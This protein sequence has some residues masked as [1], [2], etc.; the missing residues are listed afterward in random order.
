MY[1]STKNLRRSSCRT[2]NSAFT[3]LKV[4]LSFTISSLRLFTFKSIPLF[5]K[6]EEGAGEG[7]NLFSREKKFSPSPVNFFTLIELLVVIA[8]IAILAAMLLPTLQNSMARSKRA[9]CSSNLKQLGI[10][11]NMYNNDYE[12]FLVFASGGNGSGENTKQYNSESWY[13][14]LDDYCEPSVFNCPAGPE[15]TRDY[16][17]GVKFR[18]D[19]YFKGTYAVQRLTGRGGLKNDVFKKITDVKNPSKVP[20]FFDGNYNKSISYNGFNYYASKSLAVNVDSYIIT[21]NNY[22]TSSYVSMFGLWHNAFGNYSNLDGSAASL[23]H[24]DVLANYASYTNVL[25]WMKGE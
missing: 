11:S 10:G 9:N 1:R 17:T 22:K 7:E 19:S 18:D 25:D 2:E 12:G 8:I 13:Q 24:K 14:Q 23:S 21:E 15:H 5:L 6:R 3:L 16:D 20:M 4:L